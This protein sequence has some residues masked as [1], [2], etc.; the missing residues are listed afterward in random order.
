MI[1]LSAF[2]FAGRTFA[3]NPYYLYPVTIDNEVT[4]SMP[5]DYKT[6][7]TG[8]EQSFAA[9]GQFGTMLLIRTPNPPNAQI[10]KNKNGLDNVFQEYIKKVQS[11]LKQGTIINDHD[12]NMGKLEVCDFMLQVDTGAGVQVRHF[13]LLYTKNTTYT[14]EYLY[15]DFRKDE[16]GGE[17]NAF[18]Q[19]IKT[20]PDLDRD[21]QYIITAQDTSDV[22]VKILLLGLLPL[23][24]VAGAVIYFRRRSN[25]ELT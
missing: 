22:L 18:F 21:D 16:A 7:K 10:V 1:L 2:Q 23:G 14:F 4:V 12:T 6:T 25:V 20:A 9:N 11:S 17:M 15:D 24:V 13:R 19:S 8:D 5:K 3:Q